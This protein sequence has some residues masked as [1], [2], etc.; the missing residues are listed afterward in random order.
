MIFMVF[1]LLIEEL[2]S[3]NNGL[4]TYQIVRQNKPGREPIIALIS[5]EN[6][7]TPNTKYIKIEQLS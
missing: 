3:K 2:T 6:R 1:L 5:F 7:L 4:I